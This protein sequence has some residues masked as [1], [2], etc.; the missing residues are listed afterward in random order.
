MLVFLA[1]SPGEVLAID[2]RTEKHFQSRQKDA[3]G[4]YNCEEYNNTMFAKCLDN[5]M[6]KLHDLCYLPMMVRLNQTQKE[7]KLKYCSTSMEAGMSIERQIWHI[8]EHECLEPCSY[9][10]HKPS[11]RQTFD[12]TL[13]KVTCYVTCYKKCNHYR[14]FVTSLYHILALRL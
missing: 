11:T 1:V 4:Q 8:L 13:N 5:H 14:K 10:Q 9:T 2:L 6:S 3:S 12:V 7:L